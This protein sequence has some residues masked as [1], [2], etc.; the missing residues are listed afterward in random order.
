MKYLGQI[1]S[2]IVY[3]PLYTGIMY[4]AIAYPFSWVMS[5]SFWK[6]VV[7]ILVLG[8]LIEG[9]IASLQ[10]FAMM[11]FAWIVKNNKVSFALSTGLCV[12]LPICNI[13]SLWRAFLGHGAFGVVVAIILSIMLLQFVY[14]S[15]LVLCGLKRE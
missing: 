6:M 2:A 5:L 7:A 10:T 14:G 3:T 11:P 12:I 4:L 13:V 8:G 15:V 9:L 1:L